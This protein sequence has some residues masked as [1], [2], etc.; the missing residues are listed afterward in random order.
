M[1]GTVLC[2]VTETD[3][4][5]GALEVAAE[6]SERL[7]LRLVLAH[8]ADGTPPVG[9]NG[10]G[11][12]SGTRR[13]NRERAARLVARLVVEHGLDGRAE[14]RS[15]VGDPAPL[16]GQIAAEEAADL[17]VV[18]S[19]GRGRLRRGLESRFVRELATE[20]PVPVLIAPARR[21]TRLRKAV[22]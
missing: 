10:N 20:T 15:A 21:A 12:K 5:R 8:V 11:D 3:E 6:L 9:G 13:A 7:G 17:I 4:A 2:G 22:A 1:R 16:L 18:G 14:Q 19:R